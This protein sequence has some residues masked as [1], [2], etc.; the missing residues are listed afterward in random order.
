MG[1]FT[2]SRVYDHDGATAAK[3]YLVE[4]LW[5]RGVR[6]ESV[7]LDGWLKD[8][9]PTTQLRQWFNHDAAKWPEFRRR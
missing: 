7:A 9:A 3:V 4:R 8:V 5:P 2:L 6:R 1:E